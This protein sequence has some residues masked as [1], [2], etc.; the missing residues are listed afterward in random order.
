MSLG[1]YKDYSG[2]LKEIFPTKVQKISI[3][4]G[5]SCP[6]RDGRLSTGGCTYCNNSAFN[7][8]YCRGEIA[9]Q[10]EKG[11]QFFSGKY[12]EMKYL[13][14][15]QAFTG[16]YGTLDEL[17]RKYEE[18][19]SVDDVVGLIIGTRPD[20][21]DAPLLDYLAEL[22]E[23]T[24]VC[25]EYGVE[26]CYDETL[27][28][29]NRGHNFAT[30]EQA[31][32]MT[33][34]RGIPV[35]AHLIMGLP[36]ESREMMLH[37]ADILSALPLTLLKLHQLQI[38]RGTAMAGKYEESPAAYK[39]FTPEDYIDLCAEFLKRL[40]PDII[41]E[42]FVS[43]SPSELLIAPRWGLKNHEFVDKLRKKLI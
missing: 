26:S 27:R 13:A 11:K 2:Y 35:C 17:K 23:H 16:T 12:P 34:S 30:S 20:C 1:K 43:Q 15:F 31:I 7:P 39:L 40:R 10:L 36:G 29:I 37:E 38:V 42:R 24:Y 4:G 9:G 18:A 8:G 32:R 6:N 41:V 19:L 21:V 28:R 33:A 3:N 25:I 14:Y 5:F 22:S